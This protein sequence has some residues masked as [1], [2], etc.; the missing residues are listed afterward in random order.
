MLWG[1]LY[2]AVQAIAGAAWW[3]AVAVS[4]FVR[5]ATLGRLDAALVAAFDLPLFVGASA[6]A[7]LG[8]RPTAWVATGWT[9]AVALGLAV[10]A[11]V[12]G[13]AGWG[14]LVMAAAAGA[15][16]IALSLVLLGRVPTAWI[17]SGPFAFRPALPR[18]SAVVHL[19]STL[20]QI[21]VFWG[22]FL[23]VVPFVVRL[24]ERRWQ[25]DLPFPWIAGPVGLVVLALACALGIGSAVAMS[26]RGNGTPLPTAMP[27]RLV[28]AG[29]YRFIRNPMAVAGIVQ[30]VAVGLLLSSWLVVA[31][32]S[33]ARCSG[34][35][36]CARSRRPTS[37]R[38]SATSSAATANRCGAGCLGCRAAATSEPPFADPG[39]SRR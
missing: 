38:G 7:A 18:S 36:R 22:F 10:Y 9:L 5:E 33:W 30:G 34:T 15:S 28:I 35:T 29:P 17:A 25:V 3:V 31:Y 39:R 24:L 26:V 6:L 2:F 11:T 13:E 14:V 1:R 21:V 23:V 16:L 27:N 37:S 8:W 32:A 12:T 4:P 19:V 20:G